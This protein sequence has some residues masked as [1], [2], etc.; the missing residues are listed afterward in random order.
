MPSENPTSFWP[1]EN[2]SVHA[3]MGIAQIWCVRIIKLRN[4][5]FIGAKEWKRSESTQMSYVVLQR[6]KLIH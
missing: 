6:K 2:F 1:S 3:K 4:K 5:N